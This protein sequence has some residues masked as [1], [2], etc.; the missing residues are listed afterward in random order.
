M[1]DLGDEGVGE[2]VVGVSISIV[3]VH[4]ACG[5]RKKSLVWT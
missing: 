1:R 5:W 2:A 4:R 3:G